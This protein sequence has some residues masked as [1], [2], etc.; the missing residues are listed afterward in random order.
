MMKIYRIAPIISAFLVLLAV[1][2]ACAGGATAEPTALPPTPVPPTKTPTPIPPTKKP[3]STRPPTATLEPTPAPIGFP[4]TYTYRSLEITVLDVIN[5]ES[6]HFGDIAGNW[7]TFYKPLEGHFLIDVGVLV[8]N[9]KPGNIVRLKWSN[10]Y[11]VE[12]NGDAW[13]P[14]WGKTKTVSVGKQVDP[15]II[16]LS[17]TNLNGEDFIE[18]DNDTYLRLIFGV[19]NDPK[20]TILFAIEYSPYISF[21]VEQ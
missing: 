7:E 2:L 18:F 10:V 21:Q 17:S 12:A 6:V 8:R 16:G 19:V 1:T 15:F 20:Q 3:T 9:L 5:R 11:I 14:A 13:Y 4:I